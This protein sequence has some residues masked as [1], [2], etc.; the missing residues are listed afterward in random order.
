MPTL[1]TPAAQV[2]VQRG[3]GDRVN[4]V[5]LRDMTDDSGGRTEVVRDTRDLDPATAYIASELSQQYYLGYPAT[6]K[7]DGRWH[8]IR[9]DI[10][11]GAVSRP[12]AP[13]VRGELMAV[14][15]SAVGPP[16]TASCH[17]KLRRL[18]A[19]LLALYAGVVPSSSQPA[20]F[21]LVEATIDDVRAALASKFRLA[22]AYE[23]GTHH[24]KPPKTTPALAGE[25]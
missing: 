12:R 3:S 5:A 13:G 17:G 22:Y 9:V 19:V 16:V 4:V 23:Q 1:Q 14:A 18:A 2:R 20:P 6:G 15:Q 7:K 25:P 11:K 8:S 10:K 21:H 24:R